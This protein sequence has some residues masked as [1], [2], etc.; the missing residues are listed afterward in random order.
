MNL[1]LTSVDIDFTFDRFVLAY[2]NNTQTDFVCLCPGDCSDKVQT[3]DLCV[4]LPMDVISRP[5]STIGG[6][7]NTFEQCS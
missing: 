7:F 5:V 4:T 2:T 1:T 6:N 3:P